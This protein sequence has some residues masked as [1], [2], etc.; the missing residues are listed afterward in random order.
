VASF[1]SY[2]TRVCLVA[3]AS[4]AWL[5]TG[6]LGEFGLV[7]AL[8]VESVWLVITL[9]KFGSVYVWLPAL[10]PNCIGLAEVGVFG[11]CWLCFVGFTPP[12]RV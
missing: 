3:W 6:S 8:Q 1:P 12:Y 2:T 10:W 4:L 9:A 7:I 5:A 11:C